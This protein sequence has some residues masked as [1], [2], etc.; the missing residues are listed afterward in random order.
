MGSVTPADPW[1][2]QASVITS[3]A[4]SVTGSVASLSAEFTRQNAELMVSRLDVALLF[5]QS[6]DCREL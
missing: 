1:S 4:E 2:R 3:I 6:S 5:S